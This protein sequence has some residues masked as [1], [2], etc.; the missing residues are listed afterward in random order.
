MFPLH[1]F[2]EPILLKR[3]SWSVP[4]FF[5][6]ERADISFAVGIWVVLWFVIWVA[7]W[8]FIWKNQQE[9]S[10]MI[11]SEASTAHSI[12]PQS[13]VNAKT[14]VSVSR[15]S[16]ADDRTQVIDQSSESNESCRRV[17]PHEI[18]WFV[19]GSDFF[20]YLLSDP[21][22]HNFNVAWFEPAPWSWTWGIHVQ[23][24]F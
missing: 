24:L 15:S 10:A 22:A 16:C 8:L 14:I 2:S 18:K 5:S 1:N 12:D 4:L 13:T 7:I 23:Y 21:L 20:D 9:P 17:S 19:L 6:C 11:C 3:T